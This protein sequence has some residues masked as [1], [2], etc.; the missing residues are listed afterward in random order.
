MAIA[1]TAAFVIGGGTRLRANAGFGSSGLLLFRLAGNFAGETEGNYGLCF[2]DDFSALRDCSTTP[3]DHVVAWHNNYTTQGT[4]DTKGNSCSEFVGTEGPV[5]PIGQPSSV[6]DYIVVL[7]VTSYNP[8]TGSGS[9]SF[10]E[11]VAGPTVKRNGST[12]VNTGTAPSV[13]TGTIHFVASNN[14]NRLDAVNLTV[15][16]SPI[17]GI[18]GFV[19]HGFSLRQ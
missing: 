7:A 14:G 16:L 17:N 13:A 19:G 12:L 1:L 8:S 18:A 11:Y 5:F 2:N 10:T 9:S 15:Q 6:D 3:D 4:G